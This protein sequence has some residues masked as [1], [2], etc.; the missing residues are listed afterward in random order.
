MTKFVWDA[1]SNQILHYN[2]GDTIQFN[3]ISAAKL[4][5]RW[6][7]GQLTL[8]GLN[9]NLTLIS[10]NASLD[11]L[12][13]LNLTFVDGSQLHYVVD[14]NVNFASKW[15]DYLLG[16]DL[17]NQ[18]YGLSGND[19]LEGQGGEDTLV[20]NGG[21]DTLIGGDGDDVLDSGQFY[22]SDKKIWLPDDQGDLLDGGAGNDE[23]YGEQGNDTLLGGSGNDLLV[24]DDGNDTLDGG[25]GRNQLYGGAGNDTYYIHNRNDT[26]YDSKGDDSGTIF[27]DF[28]RTDPSVEHWTWAPGV[29][30]FPYWIDALL[31]RGS[32]FLGAQIATKKIVYFCFPKT[33]ASFFSET[34]KDKFLPFTDDQINFTKK[35]LDYISTLID[36]QFVETTNPNTG[37][38]VV[39]GNNRQANSGGYA[40]SI[41]SDHG[42]VLMLNYI[43]PSTG[44]PL[45]GYPLEP[46]KNDGAGFTP[47]LLHEIGHSLGLKHPFEHTDAGGQVALGPY[48]TGDEESMAWTMLSYT[49]SAQKLDYKTY[50]PFDIAALQDIYGVS[51]QAHP[52]NSRYILNEIASNFIWDGNGTD[53]IDGSKLT[54]A[55]TLYMEAGYW[56]YIGAKSTTIS[57]AGQITINFGTVIENAIGSANSDS[58]IGNAENN[59]IQAN[60]GNDMIKG[61]G[62]DDILNGGDG[63]DIATY[64]GNSSEYLVSFNSE[65]GQLT[66]KDLIL[67]RDGTDKLSNIELLSFKDQIISTADFL[68]QEAYAIV[69]SANSIN[70]GSSLTYAVNTRNVAIGTTLSYSLT[71]VSTA[72]LVGGGLSGTV[73]VV[74]GGLTTFTIKL[75]AD[76]LNEGVEVLTANISNATGVILATAAPVTVNDTSV[77]VLAPTYAITS[78]SS[79]VNEGASITYTVNTSNVAAGTILNYSLM[80]VSAADLVG[81]A[82]TGTVTVLPSGVSTFSVNL[83]ADNLTEGAEV[84]V[85]KISSSTGSIVATA[86]SARVNDTSQNK[87]TKGPFPKIISNFSA[88]KAMAVKVVNSIAYVTDMHNGN[89]LDPNVAAG[90]LLLI[91]VSNVQSPKLL[92]SYGDKNSGKNLGLDVVGKHAFVANADKGFQI[93]DVSDPKKLTLLSTS[94]ID[95]PQNVL[96]VGDSAF[97]AAQGQLAIYDVANPTVPK[98]LGLYQA[99]DVSNF[100]QMAVHGGVCYLADPNGIRMLDIADLSNPKLIGFY[101]NEQIGSTSDIVIQNHFAYVLSELQGLRILDISDPIHPLLLASPVDDGNHNKIFRKIEKNYD[102]VYLSYDTVSGKAGIEALDVSVPSKPVMLGSKEILEHAGNL[103]ISGDFA[104]LAS[105]EKGLQIV[106]LSNG[107]AIATYEG[108]K[109]NDRFFSSM[110]N[111]QF[112]GGD[113]I[114]LAI[115]SGKRAEYTLT[116]DLKNLSVQDHQNMRDG[117]D[118]LTQVE[119]LQFSDTAIALDLNGNAGQA[120]RIYQAA[121]DRKPDLVGLGYWINAMDKL[122]FTITMVAASFFEQVEFKALYGDNPDNKT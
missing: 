114:D 107:A 85:A 75:A 21:T 48:L 35:T 44:G 3:G 17:G 37:Y 60:A 66:I 40:Y 18:L 104:Y 42:S 106:Q 105:L 5:F 74:A 38:T 12:Q 98:A 1:K 118:F 86:S 13:H 64:S 121:L 31:S 101:N 19:R 47:I 87:D 115:Y 76:N 79:L 120:F 80:G 92:G 43:D 113:G 32:Q 102:S 2:R 88:E 56:S 57:S 46:S 41:E 97:V 90:S 10:A 25:T 58:I 82:L 95:N 27:A 89:T 77:L 6:L 69:S 122:G 81:G 93:F 78:N 52:D 45:Y 100:N 73:K 109:G 116:G 36:V 7:D 23:I 91:D 34:D 53:T 8:I 33:P 108:T 29:A 54:K 96:V 39:F 11:D 28:F 49:R 55:L 20:G 72:D 83:A 111:D 84:I 112:L 63:V 51:T 24:G 67:E 30:K 94:K 119:R 68:I 4:S 117:S 99:E 71:G 14:Q 22:D 62:G 9:A 59:D 110:K 65:N 16:N 61:A 70:E 50:S 103:T 26:V 15:G